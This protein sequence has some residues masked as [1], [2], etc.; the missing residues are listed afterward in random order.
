MAMLNEDVGNSGQEWDGFGSPTEEQQDTP[1]YT[2]PNTQG[3]KKVKKQE[4]L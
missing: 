1:F 3:S 4:F 2:T